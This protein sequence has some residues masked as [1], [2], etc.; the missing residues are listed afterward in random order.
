MNKFDN[1]FREVLLNIE[2][3]KEKI[4]F[5]E[6]S[7]DDFLKKLNKNIESS[8]IK[9]E[10]FIG[11]SFAKKTVIKKD[12]YDVDVFVRFD[13]IYSDKNLSEIL[14]KLLVGI[15]NISTI[16]G[17][18]DYYQIR[19]S[20]DFFIEVIP[21][22]KIKNSKDSQ[23][24]TDLSYSHVKYINKKIKTKKLLDDIKL[25]KAFCHANN[26]YGAESYIG[27]FS[28]YS[29]ELLVYYY[30]GF[31]KFLREVIKSKDKII[32]DIEKYYKNKKFVLIDLNS[33]KLNSPIILIDPTYKERNALAALTDETF[34]KFKKVSQEFLKN[35]STKFF[36]K[37]KVNLD[38]IKNNAKKNKFDF[39][40]IEAK[41]DKQ[42]G[43]IAGSKLLKF[44]KHL[45]SE[46]EKYFE[47]KNKGFNYNQK[48]SARFFFV[49]KPKK[50]ILFNGPNINDKKNIGRFKLEHKKTFVKNKKIFA[51]EEINFDLK[52]F[53]SKMK[54][55]DKKKIKEMY[56]S[57]LKI[58]D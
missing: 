23:N 5:I 7:L 53:I 55:K 56:L 21:V 39:V 6:S 46:I 47:I 41:T 37:Q 2:P 30:K 16:H 13:K 36:E 28:G 10:I 35:P 17:S 24:I 43:D 29:L 57:D 4:K 54:L 18:R 20:P 1:V 40:L 27:G 33:S 31:L 12:S 50:D 45:V 8:K 9:A 22:L 34:E 11:G 44:Y 48:Q 19:L 58:L 26:C 51:R 3:E 25:A 32:L 42:E 38:E 49:A 14:K 15:K 52:K